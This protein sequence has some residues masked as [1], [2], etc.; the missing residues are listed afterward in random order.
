MAMIETARPAPFGAISTF[1]ATTV[2]SNTVEAVTSTI[3][4]WIEARRT[5]DQL[6]RLTPAML[7]D[8]GLTA[9]DVDSYRLRAGTL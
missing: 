2:L 6:A 1:Q 5:A 4:S 8:I 9:A 3:R 7:E